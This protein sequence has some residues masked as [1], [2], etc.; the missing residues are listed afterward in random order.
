MTS[1]EPFEGEI[2][3]TQAEST[4]WWPDAAPTRATTRRTSW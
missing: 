1:Y 4:P 2:G 3:R